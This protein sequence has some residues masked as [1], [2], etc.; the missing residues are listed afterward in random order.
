MTD[1]E[2]KLDY[3]PMYCSWDRFIKHLRTIYTTDEVDNM[4]TGMNLI[5]SEPVWPTT[6]P[7]QPKAN[8]TTYNTTGKPTTTNGADQP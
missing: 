2:G 8:S 7:H 1:E 5:E 6:A 3:D 4:I